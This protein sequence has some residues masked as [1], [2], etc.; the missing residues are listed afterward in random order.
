M[1]G[2][3]LS[4][5]CTSPTFFLEPAESKEIRVRDDRI[6]GRWSVGTEETDPE[7]EF[8]AWISTGRR[9]S[10]TIKC[11]M[12]LG[13]DDEKDLTTFKGYLFSLGGITYID[14][15]LEDIL[16]QDGSTMSDLPET[17]LGHYLPFHLVGRIHPG[18]GSMTIEWLD[19]D[20]IQEYLKEH[21]GALEL[22]VDE[23]P[24]ITSDRKTVQAFLAEH[25][26]EWETYSDEPWVLKRPKSREKEP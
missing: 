20:W 21:P 10:Y 6:L 15:V 4:I 3:V 8:P 9:G 12:N 17:V 19:M 11:E 5:G 16:F 24:V 13:S 26:G 1:A 23:L 18:S 25:G 7:E 14:I 2:L 22:D